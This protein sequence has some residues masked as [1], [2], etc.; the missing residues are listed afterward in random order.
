MSFDPFFS[1][2]VVAL[3]VPV[4]ALFVWMEL[5]RKQRF[6]ML[7]ITAVLL[8]FL[9]IL[10]LMIRPA[11]LEK[12]NVGESILL[13]PG[14]NKAKIDSL[15]KVKPK[16][17]VLRTEQA[18][19]YPSSELVSINDIADHDINYIL[20]E[21]LPHSALE[22]MGNQNFRFI[23]RDIPSGVVEFYPPG[24]IYAN[25]V[26]SFSGVFNSSRKTKLK[27]NGP[28]GVED[29]VSLTRGEKPFALSFHPKQPGLFVY[30]LTSED[31]LGNK[32]T[33]RIPVEVLQ[34]RALRILFV[35]KFPTA[36]TRYLKNFLSEKG[37]SVAVRLQT[38]KSNYNEEFSNMAK[39][40]LNPL[41]ADL[42]NSFDLIFCDARSIG[43]MSEGEKIIVKRAVFN[44]LGIILLGS[45]SGKED[46]FSIKG[47]T[48][49][50]DTTHL[51]LPGKL[52]ILPSESIEIIDQP[53]IQVVIKNNKRILAGYKL[54][55]AGKIGFQLVQ[56]TYRVGLG[57]NTDDYSFLW[58]SLIERLARNQNK[59]I[60]LSLN[61][62]FPY[63]PNQPLDLFVVSAGND[64][65]VFSDNL[66]LPIRENVVVED[67][68]KAQ[69]LAGKPGWHQFSTNDS[70]VLNYFVFE[71]SE[72]DSLRIINQ[73][74][75]TQLMQRVL[76][77]SESQIS[78][79]YK[80]F[81]PLIFYLIFIL[82]LGFLWL[83]PKI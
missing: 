34:Q 71:N 38:S 49:T 22:L 13:T 73:M 70:T 82:A 9:S 7:R 3:L 52:Y 42:L 30:T 75:E 26:N 50:S 5:K 63:F 31:S 2:W 10:G 20:G 6:L 67:Y 59:K 43:E 66:R 32:L 44:G 48:I 40:R 12:Q 60:E 57:G 28:A 61:S 4:F 53:S 39:V 45:F 81:P 37:H 64:P 79:H 76:I 24:K 72:W 68:W 19:R 77:S 16:I 27:L 23:G 51:R 56:E 18:E 83:A 36:E 35:Q 11:I 58:S 8:V 33:E 15:L 65:E 46:F 25:K 62:P 1:T 29:S 47:K 54:F 74:K 14:F 80:P 17:K 41:N 78:I 21:G 69:S 55:G